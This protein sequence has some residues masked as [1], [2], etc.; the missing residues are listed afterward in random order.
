MI[1]DILSVVSVTID[2]GTVL[3]SK[4]DEKI[5]QNITNIKIYNS[6]WKSNHSLT[7]CSYSPQP[8]KK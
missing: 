3:A 4:H 2:F 6:L 1:I 7:V 8:Q 5:Q